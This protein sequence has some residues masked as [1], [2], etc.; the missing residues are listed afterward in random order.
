MKAIGYIRVSTEGQAVD[1]VSLD[2]QR[3]K[4]AAWCELNEYT[5]AAVHVDAGLSGKRADNRPGLQAALADV[6]R[7]RGAALVV[8]S[9]SRL[10]RSV[11]DTLEIT[12][13]LAR[14]GADLVSLTE[15]ID[16][17]TAAGKMVFRML[18]TFAEFER[19]LTA[20]RTRAAMAHK[21]TRGECIGEIPFGYHRDG[22]RLV[23]DPEAQR[24]V[25]LILDLRARG[26]SY[27]RIAAEL[28]SQG[29]PTAKGGKWDP[30]TVRSIALRVAA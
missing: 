20:E 18:A 27:R 1:G 9:L 7:E 24:A 26:W 2:A 21:R 14:S 11:R 4:L 10:A 23:P 19:D 15:K 13:R 16:T 6:A 12:D 17:T 22:D 30:A 28:V 5:L 8:Y 29:V 25:T 3:A